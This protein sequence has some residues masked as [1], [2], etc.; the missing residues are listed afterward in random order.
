MFRNEREQTIID[1]KTATNS[2]PNNRKVRLERKN[3]GER[4]CDVG[5]KLYLCSRFGDCARSQNHGVNL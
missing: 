5:K 3:I 1:L 2:V 4:F